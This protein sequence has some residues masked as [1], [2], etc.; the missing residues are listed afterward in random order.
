MCTSGT[1]LSPHE[2]VSSTGTDVLCPSPTPRAQRNACPVVGAEDLSI[3]LPNGLIQWS[4]CSFL[5]QRSCGQPDLQFFPRKPKFEGPAEMLPLSSSSSGQNSSDSIAE[6]IAQIPLCRIPKRAATGGYAAFT[7]CSLV[8]RMFCK[9]F[10]PSHRAILEIT[11][12]FWE[13]FFFF[14]IH[15]T[16]REENVKG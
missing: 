12:R 3:Y 7:L 11:R 16:S 6:T 4:H 8:S 15:L 10:L 14:R 1:S 13:T 2:S 5:L 9:C